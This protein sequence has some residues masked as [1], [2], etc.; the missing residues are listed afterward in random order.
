MS[1][2][3]VALLVNLRVRRCTIRVAPPIRPC[4][5]MLASRGHNDDRSVSL[6]KVT[7]ALSSWKKIR[8]DL[9]PFVGNFSNKHLSMPELMQHKEKKSSACL[10][11]V[12]VIKH[13][14]NGYGFHIYTTFNVSCQKKDTM[15]SNN[16]N[17]FW[18]IKNSA[19]QKRI[20]F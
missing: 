12:L 7:T 5:S 13:L 2:S 15:P 19:V 3:N 11:L 10:L 14:L 18:T 4:F 1:S 6:P 16:T 8:Y 9:L 17:I 20:I